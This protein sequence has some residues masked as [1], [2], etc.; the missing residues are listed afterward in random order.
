[1]I[2]EK[3]YYNILS[4]LIFLLFIGYILGEA[5]INLILTFNLF[6]ISFII[7]KYWK[8]FRFN[9]LSLLILSLFYVYMLFLSIFGSENNLFKNFSYIR[10]IFLSLAIMILINS[11]NNKKI[12]YYSLLFLISLVAIDAIF[13]SVFQKNL[14]GYE[15]N[16]N[17]RITGI[18][19]D[20]EVLGSFLSKSF[21]LCAV[22]Y[23]LV[24]KNLFENLLFYFLSI[25]V[26]IA[27]YISAERLAIFAITIFLGIFFILQFTKIIHRISILIIGTFFLLLI[28]FSFEHFKINVL[29]KTF[30][31]LGL[32]NISY[33]LIE[34][35]KS[36]KDWSNKVIKNENTD[37]NFEIN[38]EYFVYD[39]Y[40]LRKSN[41]NIY[42]AHYIT[43]K[44]I[45]LDNFWFGAGVKSFIKNCKKKK[46]E[47]PD[48]PYNNIRCSTHPHNIYIQILSEIGLVG[49]VL[50]VMIIFRILSK[51]L[52]NSFFKNDKILSMLGL[53]IIFLP[54][55][56]GNFF[57]TWY[58][59]ILWIFLGLNFREFLFKKS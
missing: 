43:A 17:R 45:W 9:Y 25:I 38:T 14:L 6:F 34:N 50:F 22:L 36:Y 49:F 24:Q 47:L 28:F 7:Y 30:A 41:Q 4:G 10:F 40:G 56:S 31:Q 33:S 59:S 46:Y 2:I 29:A 44:N 8:D 32:N 27:I 48:H 52:K 42:S 16:I 57:S 15:H 1:M 12:I 53:I 13:Q 58:G 37:K 21:L 39:K 19:K 20:E 5:V 55:P 26:L 11:N 35:S 3:K 54:L 23:C 18:F 51:N